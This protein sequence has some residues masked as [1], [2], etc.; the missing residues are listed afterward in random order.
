M[1]QT[2]V[3]TNTPIMSQALA[4]GQGFNVY[5]ALSADSLITPIFDLEASG[6]H[7]FTFLGSDYSIPVIT[8]GIEDTTTYYRGGTYDSRESF[9]NSISAGV[10]VQA[11]YGAFSGEMNVA[12]S[13]QYE[14]SSDYTFSYN[15]MY[16]QLAYL[17]LAPDDH[18]LTSA[19]QQRVSELPDTV[20]PDNLAAFEQFFATFG[21][22]YTNR[23]VIGA[24]LAFWVATLKTSE[25]TDYNI[26]AM[27]TAQYNGLFTSGSIST[28][29]LASATWKSYAASSSVGIQAFGADPTKA[30]AV[31][32]L[33]PF[34]PS[35]A[36]VATFQAWVDSIRTDPAIVDFQLTGIWERCGSKRQAVQAAWELYGAIMR[37]HLVAT[38]TT[39]LY[40][41]TPATPPAVTI[42]RLIAPAAQP[43][44]NVGFQ[45][46]VL[47]GSAVLGDPAAVLFDEYY[48][49]SATNWWQAYEAMYDKMAADLST[50]TLLAQGNIL[51]L[52]SFN[53]NYN[54][55]PTPA[56]TTILRSA[57]CG[58]ALT[59]WLAN[60]DSGSALGFP[61]NVL[62][63]GIIGQGQGSAV[64][65][66]EYYWQSG[67][68]PA[69]LDV[70]FYRNADASG[71][72]MGLGPS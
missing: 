67:T 29:I 65:V 3:V 48:S 35:Q 10:D 42:G 5:G 2:D 52:A 43:A 49:I 26:S 16:S 56:F 39:N 40:P 61:G 14:T 18:Y 28:N 6:F 30:V 64:E 36:S 33:D 62:V 4:L 71:Y 34:Q 23:V 24:S 20:T 32:K 11:S 63:A 13:R 47:D 54:A 7:T 21:I 68:I 66:M 22:Y 45:V 46:T 57:G 12:F 59:E 70:L 41:P 37:P 60:A 27:L 55:T 50:G 17:E 53:L 31:A 8:T 9:Q 51:L 25:L 58:D 44:D 15:S 19:F 72:T 1:T 38:T 69:E